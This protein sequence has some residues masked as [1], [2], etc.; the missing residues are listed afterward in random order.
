[1][2][3]EKMAD[4]GIAWVPTAVTME[5]YARLMKYDPVVS[6]N[7]QKN[8]DHQLEQIRMAREY[9]VTTA[10]G[11][12]AGS[13]GVDHG[14]AIIQE[15]RLLMDAGYSLEEVIMCATSTGADLLGL[16]KIGKLQKEMNAAFIVVPGPPSKLPESLRSIEMIFCDGEMVYGKK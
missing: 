10:V 11:T 4:K 12:D 13:P 3:L 7:A 1:M 16:S 14:K 5:A 8:L 2:H 6:G 9:G 15:M